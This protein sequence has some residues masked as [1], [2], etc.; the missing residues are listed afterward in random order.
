MDIVVLG[1]GEC[2]PADGW[3]VVRRQTNSNQLGHKKAPSPEDHLRK[4]VAVHVHVDAVPDHSLG[5]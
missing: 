4:C 3:S 1:C 2:H 5:L